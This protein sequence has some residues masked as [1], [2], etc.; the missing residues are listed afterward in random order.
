MEKGARSVPKTFV[1]VQYLRGIGALIVVLYHSLSQL[2]RFQPA[3]FW[4]EWG[5]IAVD[6]F[7][8]ISGFAMWHMISQRQMTPA[9]FVRNRVLRIAPF[10]WIVTTVVVAVML[11]APHLVSSSRFDPM[12]VIASY[13]FIPWTHPVHDGTIAPALIPGWTMEYDVAF[14]ALVALALFLPKRFW[15][16]TMTLPVIAVALMPAVVTPTSALLYFYSQPI[17]IE[18]VAGVMLGWLVWKG[19]RL[20]TRTAFLMM[21]GGLALIPLL[22]SPTH[23]VPE[24]GFYHAMLM[25]EVFYVGPAFAIIGGM[26][27]FE[28]SLPKVEP[29]KLLMWLG[30]ISFSLYLLHPM[31]LPAATKVWKALGLTDQAAY[32][33]VY[34]ALATLISIGVAALSYRIVEMPMARM[35]TAK[36][37]PR[38][39]ATL[40]PAPVSA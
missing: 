20:G 38:P 37:K 13:L 16:A 31:V 5:A 15:L 7:L 1:S 34:I 18:L 23:V 26:V 40:Q 19:M 33:P 28:M 12:H 29:S 27:F 24:F 35:L 22:P 10:Y 11:I 21:V 3:L 4:P 2:Q 39:A 32:N 25:H 36:R 30:D 14:Y 17:V 8:F 6:S 9:E